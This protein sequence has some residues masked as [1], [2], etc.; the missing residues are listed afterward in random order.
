MTFKRWHVTKSNFDARAVFR[1]VEM[2]RILQTHLQGML[3]KN[4]CVANA[5][6]TT[7]CSWNCK[8]NDRICCI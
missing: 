4:K 6:E 3:R 5:C 8:K 7:T 1:L 2:C